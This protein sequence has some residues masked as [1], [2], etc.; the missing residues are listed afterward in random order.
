MVGLGRA[1]ISA[2]WRLGL[3]AV[4]IAILFETTRTISAG[5]PDKKP[6][7]GAEPSIDVLFSP[8]GGCEARIVAEVG[9]AKKR[10][11][12]QMYIFNSKAIAEAII[13]AKKRDVICEIIAD[14]SEEAKVY[15][16]L[17]SLSRAGVKVLID[18]EHEVANNKIMLI[19]DDTVI[20]GSYNYT[21]AAEE[22]N[23]ENLLFIKNHAEVF[24]KYSANYDSHKAHAKPYQ[25]P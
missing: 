20:T 18:A 13:A 6:R 2:C 7:E 5:P 8:D 14:K 4:A 10:I 22:K 21:K 11:R 9:E 17:P 15:G 24:G 12:V 19:D 3:L 16:R 1:C 23:A 25:R